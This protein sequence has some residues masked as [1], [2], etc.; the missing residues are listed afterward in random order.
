MATEWDVAKN[1]LYSQVAGVGRLRKDRNDW[2]RK[3]EELRELADHERRVELMKLKA[4]QFPG[5]YYPPWSPSREY[6]LAT[7]LDFRRSEAHPL[8]LLLRTTN[9]L[10][11]AA[12]RGCM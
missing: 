3:A 11:T 7:R 12:L 5:G 8:Q 6:L 10:S 2:Y 4:H 1:A 9:P